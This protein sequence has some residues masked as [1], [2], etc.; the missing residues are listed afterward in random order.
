VDDGDVLPGDQYLL[1]TQGHFNDT[2][3]LIGTNSDEG[4]LFIRGGVTGPVFETQIRGGYGE[5][6]DQILA[7]NPHATDAEA[8]QSARNIFRDS[9][10]AWPT[11]T[12]A[13]LQSQKGKGAAYVYYF[14][15][16]TPASPNG[17]SHAD[18][19][20]Y[21]FGTLAG[22]GRAAPR[23]EDTAMSVLVMAYWTNFA[24]TGNPSGAVLSRDFLRHALALA[25]R[26]DFIIAADECYSEIYPD[27][28]APP[29]G[30]LQAAVA[31]GHDSFQ[32][33]QAFIDSGARCTKWQPGRH[34]QVFDPAGGE[35]RGI[36]PVGRRQ[37]VE[38]APGTGGRC[39]LEGS[40]F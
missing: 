12:W 4:A 26:H 10:F 6:A 34:Q 31:A 24:K 7:A 18:E 17:A 39:L 3:V 9:A 37:L 19:L 15:H 29:P 33:G 22:P 25:E 35:P 23:R 16:R 30:L 8:L 20:P 27:G 13:R 28:D 21:V 2:P 32:N 5:R 11:W 36:V 40:I 38:S 1:Y 14:D